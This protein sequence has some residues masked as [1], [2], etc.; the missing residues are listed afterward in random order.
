MKTKRILSMLLALIMCLGVLVS[1]GGVVNSGDGGGGGGNGG[2]GDRTEDGSWD[3]VDFEGQEVRLC[4]SAHQSPECNFPAADIYT[5]GPDTAGSNEVAKEV[6]AR[7][8][9]AEEDLGIKIVYSEKDLYYDDVIED[10]RSI[11]QTAA[12]NSPDIYNND[13]ASLTYSMVDGLLWNAKNPGEN[14][15][16]YFNFE[17]DGWYTEYIKGLTFDQDKYYMFAGD[18]FIDMIRMAWVIYVNN[19]LLEQNLNKMPSWCSSV[20][21]FYSYVD[22]GF[23]DMDILAD[24][25]TKIF[26]DGT[27]GIMGVAEKTDALVGFAYN[28]NSNWSFSAGSG[29]TLYYQ[30]KDDNYTP[31]VLDDIGEYQKVSNKFKNLT[32]SLGV[33]WQQEVKS[34]TECFLQG[35]FLF[36]ISR[37]GEM[38]SSALRDFPAAKGLVPIP[39]WDADEQDEYYTTVHDQAEIGAILASANAFSAASALMQYLNEDSDAVVNAYYEKGL[40]YKYNDDE[41]ARAM[42]DLIRE[43]TDSPFG[44][45]IG[46][47]CEELYTGVGELTRLYITQ[48]S[49]LSSTFAAQKDAYH[50]C[51]KKMIEKFKQLD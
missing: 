46:D 16:N 10:V 5:K 26:T 6:L 37:L 43:T 20:S 1:C 42:M 48:N 24:M 12:K 44:F 23:W 11:V 4:I 15:T 51:M 21:E 35:N 13:C 47:H 18:Y 31:K 40:K 25:S 30:D 45:Q 33:Y 28:G 34:S 17:A 36:A 19:D 41:D 8:K 50:D 9:R 29:I 32:D 14:V 39:K 2:G 22:S 27:S 49:T 38:E 7:N 3:N